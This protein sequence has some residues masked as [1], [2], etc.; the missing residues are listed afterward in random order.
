VLAKHD[1]A[2]RAPE[3]QRYCGDLTPAAC[4]TRVLPFC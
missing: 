2:V 1:S 4:T 3:P